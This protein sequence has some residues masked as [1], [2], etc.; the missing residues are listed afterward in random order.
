MVPFLK[1]EI[2]KE[3]TIVLEDDLAEIYAD[4]AK[5]SKKTTEEALQIVLKRVIETML[6]QGKS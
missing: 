3:F 5:M 4:I 6:K 2:M 1:G